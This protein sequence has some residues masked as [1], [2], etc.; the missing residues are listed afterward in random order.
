[1][2]KRR[3]DTT[4][5][6]G[7][8]A[9]GFEPVRAE[10]ARNFA[11]RGET[12]AACAIY[13]RGEKVVDLW[14]GYRDKKTG[15]V[16]EEDTL[17]PV[18]STTKGLAMM[19]HAVAH[20]RGWLDYAAKVTRYWPEFARHGK[21]DVTVRQLLSH[22]AGLCV[23]DEKLDIYTLADLDELCGILARQKPLWEPG[24]RHGYHALSIGWYTGELIRRVDPQRRSLGHFFQDEIARPLGL[25]FYIGLPYDVP[26][27]RL[28]KMDMMGPLNFIFRANRL[29]RPFFR[30]VFLPGTLANRAFTNPSLRQIGTRAFMALE[31]PAYMGIGQPRAIARAYSAFAT[32]GGELGLT[33]ATLDALYR[34]GPPPTEGLRDQLLH[35]DAVW[36]LGYL[37]PG[38]DYRFGSS[39]KA[40]GTPGAGGSFAFADPDAQVGFAYVPNR[41]GANLLDDPRE[42]ALRDAFYR[43][44]D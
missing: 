7:Q 17:A 1:M 20:S 14:G 8:V 35:I 34:A 44:L 18:F 36:S 30:E 31:N 26:G 38:P 22:Q 16:W 40:F 23:I 25:E 12:G 33:P 27:K 24:A 29:S 5:V 9:P 28:A 6:Y 4:R 19:T 2:F 3:G 21:E 39:D 15:A 11:E 43:C 13:W 10:F 37:K 41:M 32:G 42:K